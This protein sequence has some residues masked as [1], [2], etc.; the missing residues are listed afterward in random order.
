MRQIR[1][2]VIAIDRE[3]HD[4]ANEMCAGDGQYS[5]NIAKLAFSGL[6]DLYGITH[7]CTGRDV[8]DYDFIAS[9][10]RLD[11][12]AD[13]NQSFGCG[14]WNAW[15]SDTQ[16]NLDCQYYVFANCIGSMDATIAVE[17]VGW[18]R[19]KDFWEKARPVKKDDK[20]LRPTYASDAYVVKYEDLEDM[21][22]LIKNLTF[23]TL[24]TVLRGANETEATSN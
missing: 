20:I 18:I 13:P 6:L 21:R 24:K 15:V 1:N 5:G 17:F 9:G 19:K 14:Y 8:F 4:K 12:K 11:V 16:K 22:E 7:E 10:A 2:I 23:L 3:D